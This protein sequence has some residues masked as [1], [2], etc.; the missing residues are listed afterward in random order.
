MLFRSKEV[1]STAVHAQVPGWNLFLFIDNTT[2]EIFYPVT[3]NP[4]KNGANIKLDSQMNT[5]IEIP[6]SMDKDMLDK[7]AQQT[8]AVPEIVAAAKELIEK[9]QDMFQQ[10]L[11]GTTTPVEFMKYNRCM[12]LLNQV[13]NHIS[14]ANN[15]SGTVRELLYMG[16]EADELVTFFGFGRDD[17]DPVAK[18]METVSS[19]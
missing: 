9:E 18:E 5:T 13:I 16:F 19:F 14:T 11:D 3:I 2:G 8:A 12:E 1:V 7:I 15:T 6:D 10:G 17:V 4:M